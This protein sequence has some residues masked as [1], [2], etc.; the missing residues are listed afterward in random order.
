[1]LAA[2][3]QQRSRSRHER[4]ILPSHHCT[5]WARL[6]DKLGLSRLDDARCVIRALGIH[7][8]VRCTPDG[9]AKQSYESGSCL[10]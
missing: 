9:T 3:S 5:L 6:L 7:D 2:G 8:L 10:S 1:M 4:L